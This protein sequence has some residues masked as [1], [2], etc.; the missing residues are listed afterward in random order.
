MNRQSFVYLL[1]CFKRRDSSA[2]ANKRCALGSFVCPYEDDENGPVVLKFASYT[3][4]PSRPSIGPVARV[5]GVRG[6]PYTNMLLSRV[7]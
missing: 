4:L 1:S 6:S 7:L 2:S 3:S 5:R